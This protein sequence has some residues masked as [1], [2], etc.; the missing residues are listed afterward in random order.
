[1][2]TVLSDR[3]RRSVAATVERAVAGDRPAEDDRFRATHDE[4]EARFVRE[5]AGEASAHLEGK[6]ADRILAWAAAVVPRFVV[7]SSFGADS[8]VLLHL[9]AETA[10][11]VPVLFLD[12]GF[13]FDE[14]LLFRRE[15]ARQLGLSVID[16]RPDLSVGQ[17]D[18]RYGRELYRR[19]PDVCCQLR[20]TVPLRRALQSFDGW[21]TGVR[22]VQ[23]PERTATP[24]V[25]ARQHDG[26]WLVKVAPLATWTDEDVAR[27]LDQHRLPRH[28]LVSR[29]YPS[30][31]CAP[32]TARVED[33]QDARAGRWA[34]FDGKTECGIHLTDDGDVVRATTTP[35]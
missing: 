18:E 34:D 5:L 35:G 4:A 1:M 6:P 7:T 13:H 20:K 21:A 17:Q 15:L 2:S 11:E 30:V 23:T 22:R 3:D 26:R 24:V 29:G 31:G 25:E 32:C 27:Y 16:L 12:T 28:P 8:A 9:L 19:D 10:P 14:T 33:G